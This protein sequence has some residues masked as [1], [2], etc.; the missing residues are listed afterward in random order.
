MHWCLRY[1]AEAAGLRTGGLP[2]RAFTRVP[3]SA[4]TPSRSTGRAACDSLGVRVEPKSPLSSH[5]SFP[6]AFPGDT[7]PVGKASAASIHQMA[8]ASSLAFRQTFC[9]G[10]ADLRGWKEDVTGIASGSSQEAGIQGRGH[11]RS[12]TCTSKRP[13][14]V[15][16]AHQGTTTSQQPLHRTRRL[17]SSTAIG[18]SDA[19][20]RA[21][22]SDSGPAH[23]LPHHPASARELP[24][25]STNVYLFHEG[26]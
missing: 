12:V 24:R 1:A 5:P 20:A 4:A 19:G 14:L 6:P 17:L 25:V 23:A 21:I 8:A 18:I 10:L 3:G 9:I 2:G 13:S 15:P 26:D 11:V 7:G 22:S 16:W